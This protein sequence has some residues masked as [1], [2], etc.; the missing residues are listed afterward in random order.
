MPTVS[1][2]IPT[3]NRASVLSRAINSVLSQSFEDLEL[4]IVDDGSTDE[5]EEVIRSYDDPRIEYIRFEVNKGANTARKTGIEAAKGRYISFLDSDDKWLPSKVE[6]Q[7]KRFNTGSKDVGLVYTGV[8]FVNNSGETVGIS[9]ATTEGDVF[10]Q[11]LC[12]NFVGTFSAAMIDTKILDKV[13]FPDPEVGSGQDWEYF[14][15]CAR[16][17]RFGAVSDPLVEY[18]TDQNNRISDNHDPIKKYDSFQSIYCSEINSQSTLVRRKI[19]SCHE[20]GLGHNMIR[21]GEYQSAKS[22]F[23]QSII[24]YPFDMRYY[25]WLVLSASGED[26][27]NLARNIKRKIS[28]FFNN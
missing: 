19:L 23:I 3:Y 20:F 18:I 28:R 25:A 22:H 7:V 16:V 8:R 11:M 9:K 27:F 12:D 4:V 6:Q 10:N 21:L 1:V 15:R 2:V 14:T 17:T 26:V 24:Y 5:T 13:G